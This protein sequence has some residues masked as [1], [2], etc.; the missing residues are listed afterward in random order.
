MTSPSAVPVE[1]RSGLDPYKNAE[2][3]EPPRPQTAKDWIAATGPGVILLGAS[4]GSGEFLLGPA[5]IVKHGFTLLWIAAVAISLQTIFNV[6]LMRYTLATGEPVLTGFMR[7]K[8]RATFWAWFYVILGFLQLGWPAWAG[9]AAG[10]IFFLFAKRLPEAADANMVYLCGVGT[11]LACFSILLVG[12]RIERTLEVLNW[13]LVAFIMAGLV[14]LVAALVP[15]GVVGRGVAGYVGYD[16]TTGSFAFIPSGAD[17][18]LLG[19][20][21]AFSGAGGFGNLALSNW[22]RDK[23]YGMGKVAGFIPGAIGGEVRQLAHTG[24]KFSPTPEAMNRW[25]GWWRLV[26]ADQYVVFFVGAMLGMLMPALLYVTFVPEGSDIRGLGVAAA[27][28]H[29]IADARGPIFGGAIALMAVWVLFKTQLDLFEGMVRQV[30]DIL[31]TG[32]PR[33][34]QWRTRDV[35]VVYYGVLIVAV[36]WGLIALRMA[37]PIFL[38]QVAANV[39]G[40]TLAITS[41]HLLYINTKYLPV[42]LRPSMPRRVGLVLLSIF[43]GVFVVRWLSGMIS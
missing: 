42:E 26:R 19:A 2:L 22:A 28:A 17:W 29:A 5:V 37:Q 25:R 20:F 10:A 14:L 43:Y 30:T 1:A 9:T 13:V 6:E 36:L 41:L 7:T 12:K 34:R 3:P 33:L 8:P 23:G 18:F 24:F 15:A 32:S 38:L 27:L 31:W 35:R 11:Y 4:I 21:A 39:G 40:L 16:T